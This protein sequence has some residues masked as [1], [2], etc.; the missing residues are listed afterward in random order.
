M[1]FCKLLYPKIVKT[2]RDS[3]F[4]HIIGIEHT[5]HLFRKALNTDS[6]HILLVGPPA[7]AKTMFLTSLMHQL[8]NSYFTDGTNS[9]KAVMIDFLFE[10]RPRY[11]A[12]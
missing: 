12:L 8:K 11:F 6:V 3:L 9:T 5:K 4:G 2:H 1:N 7:S 10:N